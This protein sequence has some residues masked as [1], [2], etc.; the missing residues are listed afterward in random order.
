MP[1]E[2]PCAHYLDMWR[3]GSE[4]LKVPEGAVCPRCGYTKDEHADKKD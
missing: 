1:A 2:K 4:W 3:V